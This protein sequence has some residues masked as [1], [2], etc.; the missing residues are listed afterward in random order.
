MFALVK[1]NSQVQVHPLQVGDGDTRAA[2][3]DVSTDDL[4]EGPQGHLGVADDELDIS[5]YLSE[6]KSVPVS[7]ASYA[8]LVLQVRE[9]A[10]DVRMAK[11][12]TGDA[13]LDEVLVGLDLI[14]K[15]LA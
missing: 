14:E 10:Y 8:E 13:R 15:V 6:T 2:E 4:S 11:I 12:D 9:L 5:T 1:A 7:K 3:T